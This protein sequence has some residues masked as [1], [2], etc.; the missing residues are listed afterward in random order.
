MVK[1]RAQ[2]GSSFY[3][4]SNFFC[5]DVL[6]GKM[7]IKGSCK[8]VGPELLDKVRF[9]I[10]LKNYKDSCAVITNLALDYVKFGLD[11][12]SGCEIVNNILVRRELLSKGIFLEALD[13]FKLHTLRS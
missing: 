11:L 8:V 13:L 12:L 1:I 10:F 7:V 3:I 5:F 6:S 9:I 2:E 4:L